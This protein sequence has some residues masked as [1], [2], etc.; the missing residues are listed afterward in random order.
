MNLISNDSKTDNL[1]LHDFVRNPQDKKK[2]RIGRGYGSGK[3]GHT[4]GYGT[5]GQK[6]RSGK[7]IP[8][9]FEGGQ[10]P[11]YKRIPK[12]SGFK[13]KGR[14][15]VVAVSLV[16]LNLFKDGEEVT[17]ISFVEKKIINKVPKGG[18]KILANGELHKKLAISGCAFSSEAKKKIE[19]SG[20][21]IK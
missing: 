17:P 12:R 10:V 21:T 5:K 7:N 11:L 8:V 9:G 4:T 20:S 18:V 2:K 19:K 6:A 3:G 15:D 13:N 14:K 1:A 16:K